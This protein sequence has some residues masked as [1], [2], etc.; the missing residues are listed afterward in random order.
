VPKITV[1]VTAHSTGIVPHEMIGEYHLTMLEDKGLVPRLGDALR[2][3]RAQLSIDLAL[4]SNVIRL[5]S[6]TFNS[7][8][9]AQDVG[10]FSGAASSRALAASLSC[11]EPWSLLVGAIF[12]LD[13]TGAGGS[14]KATMVSVAVIGASGRWA[15]SRTWLGKDPAPP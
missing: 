10:S 14:F 8:L 13:K 6:P 3:G 5:A 12:L 7:G 2:R 15:L 11:A 4:N 1:P 9:A